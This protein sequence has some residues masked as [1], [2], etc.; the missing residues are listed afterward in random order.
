[1]NLDAGYDQFVYFIFVLLAYCPWGILISES[2]P[3]LPFWKNIKDDKSS[4]LNFM[5]IFIG[6]VIF[7]TM[8]P[9]TVYYFQEKL[10]F[11]EIHNIT[12]AIE[13]F[14]GG[15]ICVILIIRRNYFM[16]NIT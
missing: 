14:I 13:S 16:K 6:F 10:H 7:S 8:I 11:F 9:L 2:I 4:L 5:P 12:I 3:D 1:M 15:W